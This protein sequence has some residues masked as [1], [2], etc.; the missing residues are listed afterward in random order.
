MTL[1]ELNTFNGINRKKIYIALK[2]N[3]YDVSSSVSYRKGESYHVLAG[4][5]AS[6]C[7]AKMS[8]DEEFLDRSKS[9]QLSKEEQNTL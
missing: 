6:I 5:D 1:E 3:I 7:L 2:E 8:M 4:H 9:I